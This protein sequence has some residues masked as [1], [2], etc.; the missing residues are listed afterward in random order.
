MRRQGFGFLFNWLIG[1]SLGLR[2]V[3]I[4][5]LWQCFCWSTE[6]MSEMRLNKKAGFD[7]LSGG[8]RKYFGAIKVLLFAVF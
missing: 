3:L 4:G 5:L 8:I 6:E 7:R 2:H 1:Y